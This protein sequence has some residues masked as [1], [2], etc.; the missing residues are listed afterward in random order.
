[1]N[2]LLAK[3]G[4]LARTSG[5]RTVCSNYERLFSNLTTETKTLANQALNTLHTHRCA[6]SRLFSSV[7]QDSSPSTGAPEPD[8]LYKT[9]QVEVR[10]HDPSVLKSYEFFATE[11]AKLLNI[12]HT[13]ETPPKIIDKWTLLKSRHNYGKYHKVQYEA[14][15]HFKVINVAIHNAMFYGEI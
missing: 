6:S 4:L 15:T 9:I 7:T 14:R 1:M 2:S 11:A 13:S 8:D 12:L 3:L 5:P 10:G